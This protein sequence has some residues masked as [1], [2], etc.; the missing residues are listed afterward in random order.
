MRHA[1]VSQYRSDQKPIINNSL[2][3]NKLNQKINSDIK[4]LQNLDLI[5]NDTKIYNID[6]IKFEKNAEI[7]SD[8]INEPKKVLEAVGLDNGSRKSSKMKGQKSSQKKIGLKKSSV[9]NQRN[10][11]LKRLY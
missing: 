8:Q 1:K 4:Q 7:L 2:Q 10:P 5:V 6:K 3:P 9:A 11:Y